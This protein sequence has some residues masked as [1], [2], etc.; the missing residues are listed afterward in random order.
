MQPSRAVGEIEELS[1]AGK[2]DID[3]IESAEAGIPA[4]YVETVTAQLSKGH[5]DYLIERHGTL[6]LDPIPGMS[7]TDPYNWPTWKVSLCLQFKGVLWDTSEDADNSENDE[8]DSSCLPRIDGNIHSERNHPSVFDHRQRFRY[9]VA[10][11]ELSHI[12]TNRHPGRCTA[13]LETLVQPIR[14]SSH[15]PIILDMQLGL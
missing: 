12:T 5:R 6:D 4:T 3:L 10:E 7:P 14:S 11:S 13:I 9:L 15:L 2:P 1:P 8:L